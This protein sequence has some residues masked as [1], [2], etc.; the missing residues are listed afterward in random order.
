MKKCNGEEY[1]VGDR[2]V[3]K[4]RGAGT[5]SVLELSNPDPTSV[6]IELDDREEADELIELSIGL[7]QREE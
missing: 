1:K 5:V 2:L 3:H 4:F 7:I 6:I